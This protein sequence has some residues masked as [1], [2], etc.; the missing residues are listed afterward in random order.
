MEQ[1]TTIDPARIMQV[2]MGFWASKTLLTAVK[3]NLFTVLARGQQSAKQIKNQLG[4]Q[5]TD[6]H[7][8]DWLDTLVSLGFLNREGIFDSAGYSN[9][10]DTDLFLD[11]NKPSYIGGILQMCNN[12]IYDVWSNLENGLKTGKPQNESGKGNMD[13]FQVL[14]QD[15][16][17]LQEFMDAMSGIQSGNFRALVNKFDFDRYKIM[18]DIGG[19]DAWL[20]IQVCLKHPNI[21][22]INFD[23]APVEPLANKKIAQFNLQDRI[24]HHT[25][26]FMRDELPDAEVYT[27]GNILHGLDETLKQQLINKIYD[28]L[29]DKGVFIAIENIIDNDRRQNTFGLLMSLNMLLENGDGFDYSFADFEK[30][31]TKAGFKKVEIMPLTG[32]CSAAIAYK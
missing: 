8:F 21:Q 29:P 27:M 28:K 30:W 9:T 31:A 18:A 4:L 15:P 24:T 16:Q 19:A 25:G 3:L 22:C 26:D 5:T 12:R 20:S 14:Y 2:G 1:Q 11:K 23:L 6:R 10:P 17:K 13:L 7:V 32:P